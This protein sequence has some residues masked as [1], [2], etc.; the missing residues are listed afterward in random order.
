MRPPPPRL[1]LIMYTNKR[2]DPS[3]RPCLYSLF[4]SH[5]HGLEQEGLQLHEC[6]IHEAF[7]HHHLQQPRPHV[8]R[9]GR[10]HHALRL[11]AARLLADP[12]AA[13]APRD[14]LFGGVYLSK[15]RPELPT[16][17]R[18]NRPDARTSTTPAG[19]RGGGARAAGVKRRGRTRCQSGRGSSRP[20]AGR[21]PVVHSSTFVARVVSFE[22]T[23]TKHKTNISCLVQHV[24]ACCLLEQREARARVGPHARRVA[25]GQAAVVREPGSHGTF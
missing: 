2:R 13:P 10:H 25:R 17:Q 6:I 8:P 9:H 18:V 23:Q 1:R 4:V 21:A 16:I 3:P 14:H 20:R 24:D 19:A 22:S 7:P 15:G 11:L 5:I 12:T